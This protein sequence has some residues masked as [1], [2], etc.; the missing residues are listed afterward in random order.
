[1]SKRICCSSIALCGLG[2]GG[3]ESK[4]EDSEIKTSNKT[5]SRE[6]RR[7]KVPQTKKSLRLFEASED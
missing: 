3:G 1:M 7:G 6:S 4:E 2:G 5:M